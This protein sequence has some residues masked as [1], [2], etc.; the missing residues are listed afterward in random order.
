MATSIFFNGKVISIPGSYSE[1]DASGLDTV[2]TSATGIVAL[3]GTAEGGRAVSADM[4]PKDFL[5]FTQPQKVNAAFRSGDLREAAAI[6]FDPSGDA[7]IPGG[8]QEVVCMKVNQAEQASLTLSNGDGTVATLLSRDYGDYTNQIA[9]QQQENVGELITKQITV[10]LEDD[11]QA[12]DNLGGTA[13]FSV[14]YTAPGGGGGWSKT[15]GQLLSSGLKVN[16]SRIVAGLS[17]H[18][19]AEVTAGDTVNVV[20]TA[21]DSGKTVTIYGYDTSNVPRNEKLALNASGDATGIQTWNR[22]L[23]ATL[24]GA[25]VGTID[26][27]GSTGPTTIITFTTGQQDRGVIRTS[28]MYVA[29]SKLSLELDGAPAVGEDEL[30][31]WGRSST[32]LEGGEVVTVTN[33]NYVQTD[34]LWSEVFAIVLGGV[35]S[36]RNLVLAGTAVQSSNT[37][38]N[39]LSKLRDHVNARSVSGTGFLLTIATG[40]I[41]LLVEELDLTADAAPAADTD[42]AAFYLPTGTNLFSPASFITRANLKAVLDFYNN[43]TDLVTAERIAFTPKIDDIEVSTVT[44]SATYTV[45]IDGISV[46]YLSDGSATAEEVQ[47]GLVNTLNRHPAIAQRLVAAA[48]G[49]DEVRLTALSPKGF[50]NTTS[51]GKLTVASVQTTAGVGSTPSDDASPVFL[52]GG[53]EGIA[54]FADY[55]VALNLLKRIRVNSVVP[56]TGDPAVHAAVR[57]HCDFMAGVGRSERDMFVGFSALDDDGA[58]TNEIPTKTEAKSQIVDLN[59]RH[60]RGFAQQ[61]T[62]FDTFGNR[63]DFLPWFQA[64]VAAGMQAGAPFVGTSLTFKYGNVLDVAQDTSWNPVDDAEELIQSGL[65]FMER[66]DGRGQRFVR[67][68]TTWLKSNNL[69]FIEGSVNQAVNFASYEFRTGMEIAVGQP[70]FAGT[71]TAA[72]TTALAKLDG[73]VARRAITNYRGLQFDLSADVLDVTAEIAPIIPINFVKTTLHLVTTRLAA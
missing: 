46:T 47:A 65:C 38:Q 31:L 68:V 27:Q 16:A 36:A 53:S 43:S 63:I 62:R 21:S 42:N 6:C 44:N 9:V 49:A 20:G 5:R 23:G 71:L 19:V 67:N 48:E 24:S 58:P 40:N 73:L 72:K 22:V 33:T 56:L 37:T 34:T 64:C 39:T 35:D 15:R 41:G 69:A 11:V 10:T 2:G 52:Q 7:A 13:M 57:A 59:T 51:D 45:I 61:I 50:S 14:S 3:I 70:G 25:A 18:T 4:E 26:L 54:T 30:L 55:Q 28:A 17:G 32:G 8:A 12:G 60:A 29:R 66:V 1:V